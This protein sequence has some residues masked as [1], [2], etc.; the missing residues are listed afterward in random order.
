MLQKVRSH[1]RP[2]EFTN[3]FL[4]TGGTG[5]AHAPHAS[6]ELLDRVKAFAIAS[7]N[8]YR[9]LPN[10]PN[11][12]VPGVQFL[13]SACSVSANYHASQR[14]RSRAEFISKLGVVV[15]EVDESVVWLEFMRDGNIASDSELLSE[16]Q[17]LRRIFGTALRTARRNAARQTR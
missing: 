17:Q 5:R 11:A 7:L 8:F 13:R 16:A 10:N 3:I 15:E 2:A 1:Q 9:S 14:G 12:Q 6:K 4:K